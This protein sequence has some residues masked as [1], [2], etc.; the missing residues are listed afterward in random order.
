MLDLAAAVLHAAAIDAARLLRHADAACITITALAGRLVCDEGLTYRGA[1]RI[2]AQI[3]EAVIGRR[4]PFGEGE[5]IRA[6]LGDRAARPAAMDAATFATTVAPGA[7]VARRDCP[8]GPPP[9]ALD[10]AFDTHAAALDAL[11][12]RTWV[13][14]ERHLV[15]DRRRQAAFQSLTKA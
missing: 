1:H 14:V 9:D 3:V 7:F 10:A 12:A 6:A 8:G 11:R 4:V 13:R 2:A 15:A 5:A